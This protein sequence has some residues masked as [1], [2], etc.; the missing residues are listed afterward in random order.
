[1]IIEGIPVLKTAILSH[2]KQK[3]GGSYGEKRKW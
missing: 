1:M 3:H 2:L